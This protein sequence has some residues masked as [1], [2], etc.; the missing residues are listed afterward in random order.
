[1]AEQSDLEKPRIPLDVLKTW[2]A[3]VRRMQEEA[4]R[5]IHDKYTDDFRK[6]TLTNVAVVADLLR[7]E[8]ESRLER[9]IIEQLKDDTQVEELIRAHYPVWQRRMIERLTKGLLK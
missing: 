1:M 4:E 6:A 9:D 3:F 7:D 2:C 8:I 5:A